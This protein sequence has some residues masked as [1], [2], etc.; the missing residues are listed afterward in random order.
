MSHL[1]KLRYHAG[2]FDLMS[3]RP[4]TSEI[5][6]RDLDHFERSTYRRLPLAIREWMVFDADARLF[7][8]ITKFPH[9]FVKPSELVNNLSVQYFGGVEINALL[10]VFESQGCFVMAVNV[11]EGDDPSVWVSHD[12][13]D[14]KD[15][16][17]TWLLH[18]TRFS[19]CIEA[20]AWDYAVVT[21]SGVSGFKKPGENIEND[22][23]TESGPTT[24]VVAAWFMSREFRR[25]RVNGKRLTLLA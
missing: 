19:E 15:T 14:V 2:A 4:T 23:I 3:E 11:A 1:A 20:F 16:K 24:F 17:P 6:V 12:F 22:S 7:H 9:E 18:S 13:Y 10:I 25:M 21:E 8:K 5:A